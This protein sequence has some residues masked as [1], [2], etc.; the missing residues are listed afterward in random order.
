[1][2]QATLSNFGLQMGTLS[3]ELSY[4]GL[5]LA[6]VE[7]IAADTKELDSYQREHGHRS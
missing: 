1:M 2:P 4:F 3:P 6:T 5:L 7:L